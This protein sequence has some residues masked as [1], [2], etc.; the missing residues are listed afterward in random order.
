MRL[1]RDSMFNANLQS[2]PITNSADIFIVCD[3][4]RSME[5]CMSDTCVMCG[6]SR[7]THRFPHHVMEMYEIFVF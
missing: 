5:I 3:M 7:Y 1:G 4:W 2:Y 6:R